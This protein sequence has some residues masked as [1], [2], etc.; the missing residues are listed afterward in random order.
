MGG[1]WSVEFYLHRNRSVPAEKFL[2]GCPAAERLL[3][4]VEAVRGYPPPSFPPSQMWHAMTGKMSGIYEARTRSKNTLYR[5]FCV[6]DRKAESFG[7]GSPTLAMLG[8]GTKPVG[9]AMDDDIYEDA[10]SYRDRYL[11]TNPR[12]VKP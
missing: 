10:I 3:A 6:L 7:L 11:R 5:L 1:S 12:P 4:I 2:D 9:E 8:G